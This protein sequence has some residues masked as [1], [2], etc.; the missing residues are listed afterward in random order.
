MVMSMAA[1]TLLPSGLWPTCG[2]TEVTDSIKAF[3]HTV[4]ILPTCQNI[5]MASP[6]SPTENQGNR[7]NSQNHPV[8]FTEGGASGY[9]S[10]A[11][12]VGGG[13][14][15]GDEGFWKGGTGRQAPG[16]KD[17]FNLV[18]TSLL[19]LLL[20]TTAGHKPQIHSKRVRNP[21]GP[22]ENRWCPQQG[23]L[24]SQRGGG[25]GYNL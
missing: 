21:P 10:A 5:N 15:W 18:I 9:P 7:D 17:V 16:H 11:N 13:T 23:A 22:K 12:N 2:H 24:R 20:L 19:L 6:S 25:Q 1:I 14:G 3:N 8:T 4:Q